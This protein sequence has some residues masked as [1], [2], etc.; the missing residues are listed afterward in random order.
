MENYKVVQ[1][2]AMKK[3]FCVLIVVTVT[4]THKSNE[5]A[6]VHVPTLYHGQLLALVLHHSYVRC[7]HW[8]KRGEEN[9]GHFC[10]FYNIL[11]FYESTESKKFKK[12]AL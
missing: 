11:T 7:N 4:G 12:T 6:Q 3:V 2:F 9:M 10:N 1:G 5:M 8:R